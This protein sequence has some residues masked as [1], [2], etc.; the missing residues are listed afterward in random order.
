M[1]TFTT[2]IYRTHLFVGLRIRVDAP[3]VSAAHRPQQ[4]PVSMYLIQAFE[5]TVYG[6]GAW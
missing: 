2:E 1:T 6:M 4:R 3:D 5:H